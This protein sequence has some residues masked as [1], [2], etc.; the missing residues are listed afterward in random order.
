VAHQISFFDGESP[1]RIGKPIRL[2]ELFGGIG[3]Q[4][5]APRNL[6][7]PFEHYRLCEIDRFAVNSYN[8]VHG[9]AWEP[10]DVT[11]WRGEDLGIERTEDCCYILTYSYPCTSISKA[12]KMEGM[13]RDSGTASSLLWEVERLLSECAELPQILLMENVADVLSPKNIDEFSEWCRFLESK[14]YTNEYQVLNACDYGV[15]QNRERIF[16]ASWL[17]SY[18]YDFPEPIPLERRLK[19]VLEEHV[20]EKYYLTGE[21]ADKLIATLRDNAGGGD[22]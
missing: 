16:M 8:A 22:F 7:V 19:D 10:S 21:A 15:P 1:L 14:G 3:S 13:S 5:M 17:G 6:G 18:Y 2:I 12:G 4:A 20:D 9:T 11:K